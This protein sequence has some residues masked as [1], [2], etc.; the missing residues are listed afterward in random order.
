MLHD[1]VAA[2]KVPNV[3]AV[4]ADRD[5]PIYE[6][7]AGPRAV[8]SDDPVTPDSVFRIMSMTKMVCTVAAL[9][10]VERGNLELTAPVDTYCPEFADVPVLEGFDGDNPKLRPAGSRATVEQLVT[11]TTGLGYPFWNA[12]LRRWVSI[13]RSL[14]AAAVSEQGFFKR[15]LLADPGTT[16]IYGSNT[17]WLGKVVEAASGLPLNEYLEGN[18]AGPLGMNDTAF[19]MN[20]QQKA[21]SVPVHRRGVGMA[22]TPHAR[23]WG[24]MCNTYFWVDRTT[25]IAGSIHSQFLPFVHQAALNLYVDFEQALYASL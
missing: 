11:H 22:C 16:F 1:A 14:H 18:V 25:G 2:G 21:N 4:A 12:D 17:D 8:G 20:V 13:T 5:G 7:A 15:P 24:G 19:L 3:V 6:G 9:Q 23:A 10:Q